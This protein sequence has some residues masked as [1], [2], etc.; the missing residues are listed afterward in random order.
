[1]IPIRVQGV[2]LHPKL[3]AVLSFFEEYGIGFKVNSGPRSI[4]KHIKIYKELYGDDWVKK[5]PWLS[6]H[7]PTHHSPFLRAVDIRIIIDEG[8]RGITF[9]SI[10][11]DFRIFIESLDI[12]VGL[13]VGKGWVH[14]DV[15]ERRQ[16]TKTCIT[17]WPYNY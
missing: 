1:M 16:G 13:G 12:P 5:I 11:K 17:E 15:R 6:K 7:L 3:Y 10:L 8:L 2:I 4:A 9:T 14:I